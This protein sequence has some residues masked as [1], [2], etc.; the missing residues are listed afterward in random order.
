MEKQELLNFLMNNIDC[1][2]NVSLE[3][4]CLL[5]SLDSNELGFMNDRVSRVTPLLKQICDYALIAAI[6]NDEQLVQIAKYI[7]EDDTMLN[8][9]INIIEICFQ[10]VQILEQENCHHPSILNMTALING[11][12]E[13]SNF[14]DIII[15][16]IRLVNDEFQD[17][18]IDFGTVVDDQLTAI[19]DY[20]FDGFID[21]LENKM[22]T[23]K[24]E[25]LLGLSN[26][27][28][29]FF[30]TIML[31]DNSSKKNNSIVCFDDNYINI[32]KSNSKI[33]LNF[34]LTIF[35]VLDSFISIVQKVEDYEVENF[36]SID[37]CVYELMEDLRK[38]Y[39]L[40]HFYNYKILKD[41]YKETRLL[42]KC[43]KM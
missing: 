14:N 42:E 43:K 39:S 28:I 37:S 20:Y 35:K 8:E 2:N 12:T 9:S 30:N 27:A 31:I 26:Y 38:S 17:D 29:N 36:Y 21:K 40:Y 25:L 15:E 13:Y 7:D 19:T 23:N 34:D 16:L 4:F 32:F 33:N 22:I 5:N 11:I 41:N 3:D 1:F 18:L 6:V 24:K 10:Y